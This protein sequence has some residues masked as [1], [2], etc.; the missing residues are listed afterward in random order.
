MPNKSYN[1]FENCFKYNPLVGFPFP[2]AHS[3][4]ALTFSVQRYFLK[5]L[6]LFNHGHNNQMCFVHF[7][8][9]LIMIIIIM[10]TYI[11]RFKAVIQSAALQN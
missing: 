7:V 3:V 8:I 5:L 10:M 11:C 9:I 2:S 1:Q 4:K 6:N